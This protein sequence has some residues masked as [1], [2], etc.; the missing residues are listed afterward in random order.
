MNF[1]RLSCS[2]NLVISV[3]R[4]WRNE[5]DI[6]ILK[7]LTKSGILAIMMLIFQSNY[8]MAQKETDINVADTPTEQAVEQSALVITP[9]EIVSEKNTNTLFDFSDKAVQFEDYIKSEQWTVVMFWAS[10]CHICNVEVQGF[11]KLHTDKSASNIRVLGIS[12]DGKAKKA[13]AQEFINIHGVNFPNLIG[14][15]DAIA[16]IYTHY[17]NENWLGTPTYVVFSPSGK[18]MAQRAGM[19]PPKL[20]VRFIENQ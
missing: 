5:L 18:I 17:T 4:C 1:V 9:P 6:N 2:Y 15:P 10:D 19:L 8:A 20:I 14:E 16:K 12:V 7:L 3:Y 11:V 13:K